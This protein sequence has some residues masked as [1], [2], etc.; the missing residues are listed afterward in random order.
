MLSCA[1]WLPVGIAYPLVSNGWACYA[2]MNFA[3]F[4]SSFTTGVGPASLQRIMPNKMRGLS[5]SLFLMMNSLIGL[6]LGPTAIGLLTD[7]VFRDDMKLGWSCVVVGVFAQ[8]AAFLI[9][10]FG[11]DSYTESVVR[12][13]E[14]EATNT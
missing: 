1:I 3:F 8:V 11:K 10:Y 2:L 13:D 7:Y 9:F 6:G 12:L 4:F 5:S 14:W